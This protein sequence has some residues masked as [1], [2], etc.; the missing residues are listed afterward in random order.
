MREGPESTSARG[1]ISYY[2]SRK[3]IQN[4][5]FPQN[6][7]IISPIPRKV[8]VVFF[9]FFW[10]GGEDLIFMHHKEVHFSQTGA[11]WLVGK[12]RGEGGVV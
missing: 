3:V 6:W 11:S 12:G 10:G 1:V 5:L 4:G 7:W 8:L 2:L 9:F